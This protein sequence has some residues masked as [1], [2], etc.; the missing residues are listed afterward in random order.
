MWWGR[1]GEGEP[2]DGAAERV[3]VRQSRGAFGQAETS[4]G[5]WVTQ[6]WAGESR[7]L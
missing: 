3:T 4:L 6:A 7:L 2:S 1:G 5:L